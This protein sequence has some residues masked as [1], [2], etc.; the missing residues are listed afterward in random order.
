[1]S[2]LQTNVNNITERQIVDS[3][4]KA[5]TPLMEGEVML[6]I[7]RFAF[8]ANNVTYGAVGER[9]GYWQFFQ[10]SGRDADSGWGMIPVWGY[11]TV[12]A[13]AQPEIA[14]GERVYGYLPMADHWVMRPGRI[15][16]NRW[17]DVSEHRSELPPVYNSY[18]R[19]PADT[20]EDA[21]RDNLTSLLM[22]L[23]GTAYCLCDALEMKDF[24]GA[25]QVLI[26][27][28]SSK[29]SLGLAFALS[30]LP[31][32]KRPKIIGVTS[33]G[34][35][36]FVSGV[37]LYDQVVSYD[38]LD[39]VDTSQPAVIVDMSGNRKALSTLHG[40]LGDNMRWTD[41]VG[42]T[43][44]DA[45]MMAPGED[46]PKL[47]D[48]RSA[49]FFAPGHIQQR[50]QELGQDEWNRRMGA[51]VQSAIGSAAQWLKVREVTDLSS[52]LP[53]YDAMVA[54]KV[55]AKEGL[56]VRP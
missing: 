35:A 38:A 8:T 47:I 45:A 27:S 21:Q 44:L 49:M 55:N 11:A 54:G 13:S 31:E 34:N 42:L 46:A 23:Y 15:N 5:D 20:A 37:G 30:Q 7:D 48:E 53:D 32:E 56:I 28:A 29:T 22:P 3:R 43:H 16:A 40:A 26:I 50:A 12:V 51:F 1:M 14:V 25:S 2:E 6:K 36:D 10:P 41:Y 39:A 17:V 24:H 52:F 18:Q 19:F 33:A 9:I 4:Y